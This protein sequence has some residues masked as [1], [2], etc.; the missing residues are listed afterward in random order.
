MRLWY[1]I[2]ARNL[3]IP[4]SSTHVRRAWPA[5]TGDRTMLLHDPRPL[6]FAHVPEVP[7]DQPPRT[8]PQRPP[9]TDPPGPDEIPPDD[10]NDIPPLD[11]PEPGIDLP[12]REAPPGVREPPQ[13][14]PGTPPERV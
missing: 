3:H 7:P 8:P 11:E 10:P 2:Q 6:R 13:V 4:P 9:E 1:L 14:P 5:N 12:P